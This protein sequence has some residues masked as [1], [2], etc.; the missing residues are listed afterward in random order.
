MQQIPDE[1]GREGGLRSVCVFAQQRRHSLILATDEHDRV[2][3][4][5]KIEVFRDFQGKE[6][7]TFQ[8]SR[9]R[10][11]RNYG[12]ESAVRDASGEQR[13]VVTKGDNGRL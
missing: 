13:P 4:E 7:I 8:Y 2:N 10:T 3:E 12:A 11:G 6:T 5:T 1:I 9:L